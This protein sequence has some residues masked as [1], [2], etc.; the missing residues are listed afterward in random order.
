ML[1][2]LQA[3]AGRVTYL[4]LLDERPGARARV[5]ECLPAARCWPSAWSHIRC[6]STTCSTRGWPVPARGDALRA[7]M[8]AVVAEDGA[9]DVEGQLERIAELRHS[10]LF[11]LG[12]GLAGAARCGG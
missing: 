12:A 6:C 1:R 2:L 3:I 8:L 5:V 10:A 9:I 7:R 11:R 4:A